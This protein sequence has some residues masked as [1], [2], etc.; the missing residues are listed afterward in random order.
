MCGS[1]ANWMAGTVAWRLLV[2]KCWESTT[3]VASRHFFDEGM[4]RCYHSGCCEGWLH[5]V[6]GPSRFM[7]RYIEYCPPSCWT[8]REVVS[9]LFKKLS[10]F[11]IVNGSSELLR[12]IPKI[13]GLLIPDNPDHTSLIWRSSFNE[14]LGLQVRVRMRIP[15]VRLQK[16]WK[17]STNATCVYCMLGSAVLLAGCPIQMLG[18][19]QDVLVPDGQRFDFMSTSGSFSCRNVKSLRLYCRNW[20]RLGPQITAQSRTNGG[21]HGSRQRWRGWIFSHCL[22]LRPWDASTSVVVTRFTD[23]C[24]E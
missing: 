8:C 3:V 2:S 1:T 13:E 22:P 23:T 7:S 17:S 9:K 18:A 5:G 11:K 6:V 15:L 19:A 20:C 10:W 12:F 21:E 16:T 4:S 24:R 14:G